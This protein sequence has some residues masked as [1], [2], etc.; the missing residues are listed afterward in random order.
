MKLN[1]ICI[2]LSIIIISLIIGLLLCEMGSRL[3]LNPVD[4]LS[5]SLVRDNI[6]GI[7]LPSKSSG[8]DEWGFRNKNVSQSI[9]IV[10]LGDSHTYG[11]CA[12]MSESWP[13]VLGRLTEKSVYNLGLGGYG[14]NQYYYLFKTK[15][16][17]L[18]PRMII[19]GLY[20][21]DDFDGAFK[22]TYG[23]DYW[24]FLRDPI[25]IEKMDL[26]DIW[27][28]QSSITWHK[29][30]RNWLSKHS[31]IYRL[32]IHGLLDSLK[33][34]IQV[35]NAS[36]LYESTSSLIIKEKNIQE[37]FRP[38]GVLKGLDQK[39]RSVREGMR[40]TFELLHEM[41]ETCR[42]NNIQFIVAVIP[43]KEM[44]FSDYIEHNSQL[45]MSE[46]IDQV[47]FNEGKS[48][49]KLFAFLIKS[50]IHFID[51]LPPMKRSIN[52]EKLYTSS[53]C[54]MHPNK[55]GYK[56]IAEAVA[57]FINPADEKK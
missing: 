7:T 26:W 27:E 34:A 12:K 6:L 14:P 55:N 50:N 29:K 57:Q 35:Q 15:A 46:V 11:N 9:E 51:L 42:G 38:K 45:P 52:Q 13:F 39:K 28:K 2:N 53:A 3:F 36:K 31:I 41:N 44:V 10:T 25:F 47:I 20:M 17:G 19:C 54:D 18:K 49:E 24:K 48:R 1:K 22:I 30:I 56:V 8:H 5:P 37:A 23:L 21:G 40:I 4:Y 16:L 43:T 32:V 33:G